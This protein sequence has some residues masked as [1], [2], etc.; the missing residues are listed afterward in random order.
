MAFRIVV[1]KDLC[2]SSGKCVG[3]GPRVFRFDS[4]ELAEPIADVVDYDR[5]ALLKLARNCPGEA[6]TIFDES[7]EPIPTS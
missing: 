7:G 1:D 5:E 3:D 4:Q 6:I 2:I